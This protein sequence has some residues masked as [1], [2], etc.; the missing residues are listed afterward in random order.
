MKLLLTGAGG[1][2]GH[3]LS[4]FLGEQYE[5]KALTRSDLD[6]TDRLQVQKVVSSFSPD[7]ILHGAAFT[8]VEESEQNPDKAYAIN[9]MGTQNL[10]ESVIGRDVSFVY[11]S[12]T[13]NY[14]TAKTSEPY[15]EFDEVIPT[16]VYH[17][18]K[19]YGEKVVAAHINRHLILR[20]GWLFGGDMR[21]PKNFVYKRFLEA[22][23]KKVLKS[24]PGQTGNPTFVDDLARQI[25]L[26]LEQGVVGVYNCVNKGV[27]TRLDYV[28]E[29]IQGFGLDCSV[30]PIAGDKFERIAPVSP[31]EAAVNYNL[32][33]RSLDI[34][35]PWQESL[36]KYINSLNIQD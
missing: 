27:A 25:Q 15:H 2:L 18:S 35:P 7:V 21:Q 32:Q 11:L 28:K 4:G 14:G 19:F 10:V 8:N 9:V 5:I 34:M 29:I 16:T 13:G 23:G 26:L 12:S 6:I 24:D 17:R 20:T 3:E 22:Q 31:N 1:M 33:L 36:H 30:E